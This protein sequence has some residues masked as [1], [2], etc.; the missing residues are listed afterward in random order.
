MP[1]FKDIRKKLKGE[2]IDSPKEKLENETSKFELEEIRFLMTL[3]STSDFKGKDVQ[4]VYNVAFKLQNL[5]EE[6]INSTKDA[7]IN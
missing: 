3:I 1:S 5:L 2:D 7:T 6:Y 4:L